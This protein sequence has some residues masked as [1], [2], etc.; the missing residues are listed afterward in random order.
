MLLEPVP[1]FVASAFRVKLATEGW[2]RA[3]AARLRRQ[4]FCVEQGLF[5]GDDRDAIDEVAHPIVAVSSL[6]GAPDAVVGTVRIHQPEPGLWF[7]SRL[8]VAEDHRKVGSLGASLIRLAVSTATARGCVRFLAHVQSRNA[9]L[10][11]RLHWK[12]LEE[13]ELHGR[14]HHL[15]Q[16]DLAHYPPFVQGD[17]GFVAMARRAA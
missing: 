12:T 9:L 13:I 16:A 8:A 2:E 3:Q 11:R 1:G 17:H 4:V 10:F 14:P 15:M 6:L 5:G 7:G